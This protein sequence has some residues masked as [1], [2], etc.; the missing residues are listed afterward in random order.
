MS[1]IQR[2]E[3]NQIKPILEAALLASAHPLSLPQLAALFGDNEAVTHEE[4]AR[5]LEALAVDCDGRGIELKEVASGFRY[6]VR[7]D[8]HPWIARLWTERQTK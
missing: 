8:V 1:P 3:Q 4:L 6:Q 7:Q 5:A 2:M